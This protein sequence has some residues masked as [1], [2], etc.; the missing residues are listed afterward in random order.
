MYSVTSVEVFW[1]HSMPANFTGWSLAIA[2][3]AESPT[4]NWIGVA[5]QATV[6]GISSP[7][8]WIRSRRPLSMPTA[9]T[10][11]TRKPVT[12]YAARIM[13]GTSYGTASLKITLSGCTDVTVPEVG[14]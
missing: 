9:Y 14:E 12:R 10:D 5:M 11:A 2:R 3:A 8:R 7:R 6:N 4:M 13:C 1:T